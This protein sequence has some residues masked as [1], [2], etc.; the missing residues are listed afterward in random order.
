VKVAKVDLSAARK[1]QTPYMP[2]I[3]DIPK[4]SPDLRASKQWEDAF[5]THFSETRLVFS[6]HVS[7]DEPSVSGGMKNYT[8]PVSSTEP[9]IDPTLTMLRNM[10]AVAIAAT[11]RNYIDMIQSLDSLSRN[12]CLWLFALCV[13]V[14][15]PLDAETCASLRSLLRKCA[16]ILAT[17]SEM[18]EEVVMLNILMAISGRYFGQY[19]HRCE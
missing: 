5:L 16:T 15:A 4:Y 7:S 19:E 17:K 13:A 6:E 3:P 9:Q 1:E 2:E 11:L 14:D 12:N 10:D 18:D 8:K